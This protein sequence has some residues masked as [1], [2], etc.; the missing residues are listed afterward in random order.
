MLELDKNAL[1]AAVEKTS[2]CGKCGGG[3]RAICG[4]IA[5]PSSVLYDADILVTL[6]CRDSKCEWRSCQWRPWSKLK[7]EE[8]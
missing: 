2:K 5:G 3:I 7:P 8:L 4:E 6:Y 1:E